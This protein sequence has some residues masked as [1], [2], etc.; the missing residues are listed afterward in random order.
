MTKPKHLEKI[1]SIEKT[2]DEFWKENLPEEH[3]RVTRQAGTEAPFSG[4]FNTYFEDG[5]Y[6]C[7]CC[8][9]PLFNSDTKFNA[10]CGWPSFYDQIDKDAITIHRDESH[11]MIRDEIRCSK[12]DAHLGHVFPDGPKP[13]GL[14]YCLNS[15]SLSFAKRN[16]K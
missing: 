14:R 11:G 8:D 6:H 3:Y 15:V 4:E 10:G 5:T 1:E 16:K 9:Q 7:F 13:T 12:C 2:T